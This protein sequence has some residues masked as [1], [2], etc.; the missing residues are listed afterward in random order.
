MGSFESGQASVEGQ[1]SDRLISSQSRRER[2]PGSHVRRDI[3][4]AG[5]KSGRGDCMAQR[6]TRSQLTLPDDLLFTLPQQ[7]PLKNARAARTVYPH[8]HMHPPAKRSIEPFDEGTP[9]RHSEPPPGRQVKRA[10]NAFDSPP[11]RK[12]GALNRRTHASR[13]GSDPNAGRARRPIH[14]RSTPPA[15]PNAR[16]S[17][18]SEPRPLN[19]RAHS[20]P[21]F[22]ASYSYPFIDFKNLP[23]SPRRARSRSPEKEEQK[24]DLIFKPTK[25][26]VAVDESEEKMDVE[27][28]AGSTIQEVPQ[29]N[30]PTSIAPQTIE[31]HSTITT[32]SNA[33]S[34]IS[35]QRNSLANQHTPST[36]APSRLDL[37]VALSPLTP[38]SETPHCV[39]GNIDRQRREP[40]AQS[41]NSGEYVEVCFSH[42]FLIHDGPSLTEI[43]AATS[44][45]ITGRFNIWWPA[46]SRFF[47]P[48]GSICT[49]SRGSNFSRTYT[50]TWNS[51]QWINHSWS[52]IL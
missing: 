21:L 28:D 50:C 47:I 26:D 11:P 12:V 32:D 13:F 23:P 9:S 45:H 41:N 3:K 37:L 44:R 38:L 8:D 34:A 18:E 14:K 15:V 48:T 2:Q 43:V 20:V 16:G 51:T 1:T 25:L 52:Q 39:R 36:P 6:R 10:K 30:Q 4:R 27:E 46:E 33:S 22:P 35:P 40:A 24:L 31:T 17:T 19:G 7:S 49:S 42:H 5:R 29:C